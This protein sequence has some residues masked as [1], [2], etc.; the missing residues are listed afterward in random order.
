MCTVQIRYRGPWIAIAKCCRGINANCGMEKKSSS[1]MMV[2]QDVSL[3]VMFFKEAT[4]YRS[5][6]ATIQQ[7]WQNL[8]RES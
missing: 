1:R 7:M 4:S 8:I 2:G 5:K 6:N 3:F